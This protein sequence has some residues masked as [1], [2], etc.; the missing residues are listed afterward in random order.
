MNDKVFAVIGDI[1]NDTDKTDKIL[2]FIENKYGKIPTIFVGDYFDNFY[3]TPRDAER[4]A[5]WLKN[6]L[7]QSN[8]IHLWGNHDLS[9]YPFSNP[10][11]KG[12][13]FCPGFSVPK[14]RVIN[15]ILSK[16]DWDQLKFFTKVD[17]YWISHAGITEYWFRGTMDEELGVDPNLEFKLNTKIH[18]AF[19]FLKEAST[20]PSCLMSV[21]TLRGGRYEKGGLLWNDWS[22]LT[23]IPNM[24]QIVG[25]TPS[26]KILIN[27]NEPK[28]S[29]HINVDSQLNEFLIIDNKIPKIFWSPSEEY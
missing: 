25:H 21:D 19:S 11:S 27:R 22:N 18:T 15:Q 3:D 17:D 28:N 20:F 23:H 2:D 8:R 29:I 24:N 6:S 14:D 16:K 5:I 10:M 7:T 12:V 9:Y 26:R 1:H 13:A 4:V